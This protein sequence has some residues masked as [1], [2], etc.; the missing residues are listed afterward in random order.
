MFGR[1]RQ[2]LLLRAFRRAGSTGLQLEQRHGMTPLFKL[3]KNRRFFRFLI[4]AES[5]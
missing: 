2:P 4:A 3:F 1:T 5:A